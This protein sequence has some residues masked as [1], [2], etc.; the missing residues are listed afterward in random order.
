MCTSPRNN[1]NKVTFISY[2][3]REA[4]GFQAMKTATSIYISFLWSAHYLC[5]W[6]YL[7]LM[8][9]LQLAC[10]YLLTGHSLNVP[11]PALDHKCLCDSLTSS[12]HSATYR[13]VLHSEKP[14]PNH[15]ASRARHSSRSRQRCSIELSLTTEMFFSLG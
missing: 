5:I 8:C 15:C 14:A 3:R 12:L 13:E 11:M 4:D 7:T 1:S 9:L 10:I 6:Q 2:V